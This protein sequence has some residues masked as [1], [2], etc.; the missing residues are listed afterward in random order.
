MSTAPT[1]TSGL[2]T[3]LKVV[4]LVAPTAAALSA[5][6]A[7]AGGS[8]AAVAFAVAAA[9]FTLVGWG[10]LAGGSATNTGAVLGV[11]VVVWLAGWAAAFAGLAGSWWAVIVAGALSALGMLAAIGLR[12]LSKP[13]RSAPSETVARALQAVGN[14]SVERPDGMGGLVLA[15]EHSTGKRFL[16]GE[17]PGDADTFEASLPY[18][19]FTAVLARVRAGAQVAPGDLRGVVVI[20][21]LEKFGPLRMKGVDEVVACS[22]S[23]LRKALMPKLRGH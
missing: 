21:D 14:I 13:V 9:L 18:R 22:K 16:V 15:T 19:E 23:Q 10:P 17:V 2:P 20:P 8:G 7:V 1:P 6:A 4:R 11:G 5:V 3:A 12:A